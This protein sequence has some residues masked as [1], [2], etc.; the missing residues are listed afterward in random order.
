[1]AAAVCDCPD[2]SSTSSTGRP[3]SRA[4]SAAEPER[5]GSR[6]NAVEQAHRAFDH[7]RVGIARRLRRQRRKQPGRHRPAVE[8]DAVASGRRLVEAGI[9]IVRPRFRAAHGMPR[10]LSALSSPIVTEV[11]P[12]P[13]RGA[14]TMIARAFIFAPQFLAQ[15][16]DMADH[17]QGRGDDILPRRRL[18]Q[19]AQRR[20]HRALLGQRRVLDERRRRVLA[21][22]RRP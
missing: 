9:D 15:R 16:H 8:V 19:R 6:R 20:H 18:G 17:D 2:T 4:R 22:A 7:H 13:E 11:L 1:M 10:R 14:P 21:P 3:N 12:E 5:P